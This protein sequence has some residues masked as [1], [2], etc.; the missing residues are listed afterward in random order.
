MTLW[1]LQ[2]RSGAPDAAAE[3]LLHDWCNADQP[4]RLAPVAE[5]VGRF[6]ALSGFVLGDRIA[7]H[8]RPA[9]PARLYRAAAPGDERGMSWTPFRATA[10]AYARSIRGGCPVWVAEVTPAALLAA[11]P[12]AI[13]GAW[14]EV[15]IDPAGIDPLPFI[16]HDSSLSTRATDRDILTR[17]RAGPL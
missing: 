7:E 2:R 5:W 15:V 6:R 12:G 10:A 8:E 16:S 4:L 13:G 11:F 1:G 17:A 14:D 3:R 9:Q